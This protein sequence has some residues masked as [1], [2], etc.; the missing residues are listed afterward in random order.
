MA[1]RFYSAVLGDQLTSDVTEAAS[2]TS[3]AV[4]LRVSDS[5]YSDKLA[6]IAGVQAILDYLKVV[7][8]NP[9]A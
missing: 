7:E 8:T 6:V 4:E 9:I 5:I 2:T 1:D 3:E